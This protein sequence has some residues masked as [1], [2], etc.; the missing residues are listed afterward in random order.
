M[1]PFVRRYSIGLACVVLLVVAWNLLSRDPRIGELNQLLG[2]DHELAD[3]PFQ[4]RVLELENG[5]ATV[6]SPRSAQV[7]VMQFL[8]TAYPQLAG[9]SVDDPQ[10]MEAQALLVKKQSRAAELLKSQADI[11]AIRWRV[12]ERWYEE[13][14]VR[15]EMRP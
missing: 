4:F 10:M 6:S 8:R 3:F 13:R 5:I 12:D 9:V 2:S 14:G 11:G 1:D 15:L 7:P